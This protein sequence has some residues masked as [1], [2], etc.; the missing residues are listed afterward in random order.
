MVASS[1]KSI[2]YY[3]HLIL[4][5]KSI[6]FQLNTLCILKFHR[7]LLKQHKK[8]VKNPSLS[9]GREELNIPILTQGM[10][11]FF[12]HAKQLSSYLGILFLV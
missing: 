5:S 6:L 12:Q 3:F 4:I 10:V 11:V 7:Y 9:D 1:E 8:T 2:I